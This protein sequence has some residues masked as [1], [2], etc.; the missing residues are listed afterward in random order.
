[1]FHKKHGFGGNG[2]YIAGNLS[3]PELPGFVSI[4]VSHAFRNRPLTTPSQIGGPPF[5]LPDR[6]GGGCL[7]TGPFAGLST[8]LGP[9]NISTGT[10]SRCVRR[11]FSYASL[12]D[13]SGAAQVQAAMAIPDFGTFEQ[14]TDTTTFHPGGHWAV[15]G[16]YGTMT[17]T[18]VSPAD[19]LFYLHH[20]NMDRAWWSWQTLNLAVREQEISGP[21]VFFDYANQLG[22]NATLTTPVWVGLA[23]R[24]EFPAGQLLHIRKGPFC[25]TYDE[26]YDY[27]E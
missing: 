9:Q 26:V 5:D 11:D 23:N 4:P 19:P 18:Y 20:S 15:G 24:V 1:M 8:K 27:E 17:D 22:G 3:H 2:A 13:F 7:T 25:Y 10:T 6:S 21:L 14:T 12:R 16:L